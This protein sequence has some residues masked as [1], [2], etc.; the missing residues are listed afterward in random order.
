MMVL[1]VLSENLDLLEKKVNICP[2]KEGLMKRAACHHVVV[3]VLVV[4]IV[5]VYQRHCQ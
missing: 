3:V 1:R 4:V 5:G 2:R